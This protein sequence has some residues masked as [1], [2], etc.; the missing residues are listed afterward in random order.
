ML[1][2]PF[3]KVLVRSNSS[4]EYSTES[5]E[6]QVVSLFTIPQGCIHLHPP[7]NL[8]FILLDVHTECHTTSCTKIMYSVLDKGYSHPNENL[9]HCMILT[10]CFSFPS[11]REM[12]VYTRDFPLSTCLI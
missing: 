10:E 12:G 2:S 4:K 7:P 6:P 11:V 5:L 1:V 9:S 3:V 8:T